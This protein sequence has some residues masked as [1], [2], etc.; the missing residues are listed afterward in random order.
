MGRDSLA[1]DINALIIHNYQNNIAYLEKEYKPLYDSIAHYEHAVDTGAIQEQYQLTYEQGG[2][3]IFDTQTQSYLYLQQS[4][5]IMQMIQE[6]VN[7]KK[8]ENVFE[9]F[10]ILEQVPEGY[11]NILS[12]Y[13]KYDDKNFSMKKIYKFVSFGAGAH[14]SAIDT[15]IRAKHYFIVEDSLELFRLSL[16]TTP[17]YSIA[18]HAKLSFAIAQKNKEFKHS[19]EKFLE[20]EY[21][22][23]HYIKFFEAPHHTENKLKEFHTVVLSQSHL[24]FFYSSML[25]QYT[26]SLY[27]LHN[28]YNFLN[29]LDTKLHSYFKARPT[30]L[31]APGPSLEKNIAW[32][33]KHQDNFLIVAL[34]ATLP[35]LYEAKIKPDIITHFDGFERSKVHFDKV[36]DLAFFHKSLLLFSTKTPQSIV[37]LFPKRALFFFE[38]TS[39]FKNNFGSVSAFCAGSSTYL[40]LI[41]LEVQELYLLGLDL[42]LDQETLLTHSSNY[43]YQ[44]QAS[45]STSEGADFRTTLIQRAGNFRESI[46]TT[47][48]F[49]ISIDAIDSI[50]TGMKKPQ[51]EVYNL[52]D[53]AY[54]TA[55][56]PTDKE[57][58][59]LKKIEKNDLLKTFEM[60]SEKSLS[61]RE[62][63]TINSMLQKTQHIKAKIQRYKTKNINKQTQLL[64][65]LLTIE[66][67]ICSCKDKECEILSIIVH[68][69]TRFIYSYIFDMCNTKE[70]NIETEVEALYNETLVNLEKIS[71]SLEQYLKG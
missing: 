42:A 27:Y 53:G 5:A 63:D 68:N 24:N 9:T 43:H 50:S 65:N 52:S 56:H 20:D 61:K 11:K 66:N 55:T 71:S 59:H 35:L 10:K 2:F 67:E 49:S 32:V 57:S 29:L 36:A 7:F 30:L 38:S 21:A 44:Q 46:K 17:Y 18:E 1:E 47:P 8:N 28:N 64:E 48:N 60:S 23:N 3:D 45:D 54:F 41:A 19:V 25:E 22:Y 6:S 69:Y 51:Q 15:K 34:S 62:R 13:Q 12:I 37:N 26:R 39:S 58:I 40:I 33:Q 4:N 16:F 70:V 31:L 14:L